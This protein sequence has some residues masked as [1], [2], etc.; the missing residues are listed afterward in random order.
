MKKEISWTKKVFALILSGVLLLSSIPVALATDNSTKD[1]PAD[2][3]GSAAT[4]DEALSS[5]GYPKIA[6]PTNS[7]YLFYQDGDVVYIGKDDNSSKKMVTVSV[8]ADDLD[9]GIAVEMAESIQSMQFKQFTANYSDSGDTVLKS[10]ELIDNNAVVYK[11]DKGVFLF[12]VDLRTIPVDD[13]LLGFSIV[14]KDNDNELHE[15]YKTGVYCATLPNVSGIKYDGKDESEME[16][17]NTSIEIEATVTESP[18]F[19]YVTIDGDTASLNGSG[20]YVMTVSEARTAEIRV[21]NKFGTY[22]SAETASIKS[23]TSAPFVEYCNFV[24]ENGSEFTGWSN[25]KLTL[26]VNVQDTE[27]GAD[28]SSIKLSDGTL[29]IKTESEGNSASAYFEISEKADFTIEFA[30]KVGN[31]DSYDVPAENVNIDKEAPKASDF[32]LTFSDAQNA[33]DKFLNFLTFGAYSNKDVKITIDVNDNDLSEIASVKLYNGETE[34]EKNGDAF[35]LTAPEND[36]E[37]VEY[38]LFVEATDKAGNSS[39]KIRFNQSKDIKTKLSD[40]EAVRD[41]S[42]NLY[43][44]V[45]SKVVPSLDETYADK[46]VNRDFAHIT[47]NDGKY[48]V[49]GNGTISVKLTEAN[50]GIKEIK[51]TLDGG[52]VPVSLSASQEGK[53]TEQIASVSVNN[54]SEGEHTVKF[55]ATANSGMQETYEV[56]VISVKK[57]PQLNGALKFSNQDESGKQSWVNTDV[58]ITFALKDSPVDV[59]SVKYYKYADKTNTTDVEKTTDG[60]KFTVGE[61]ATYTVVA[62]DVLGNVSEFKTS[63]AVLIDKSNPEVVNEKFDYTPAWINKSVKIKFNVKDNPAVCSGVSKVTV[64]GEEIAFTGGKCEFEATEYGSHSV[65]V[66]DAAGNFS[67]TYTVGPVNIDLIA[68]EVKSVTFSAAN[69]VNEYGIYA[70]EDLTMSVVFVDP[71]NG[72]GVCS[73]INMAEIR[74][75]K[76]GAALSPDSSTLY[77]NEFTINYTL[78]KE[79]TEIRN[80]YY[81]VTDNAGNEAEFKLVNNSTVVNVDESAALYEVVATLA[82]P[83]ISDIKESFTKKYTNENDG[84]TYYSGS[85]KFTSSIKDELAGIDSYSTYFVKKDAV[86]KDADGNITSVDGTPLTDEKEVSKDS[87]KTSIDK[88]EIETPSVD[89]LESG[90]YTAVIYAK[91]LSGNGVY[92]SFDVIVD[93]TAPQITGYSIETSGDTHSNYGVYSDSDINV[94]VSFADDVYSTGIKSVKFYNGNTELG[95]EKVTVSGNKATITLSACAQYLLSAKVIDNFDHDTGVIAINS[96][97]G[98]KLNDVTFVPDDKNFEIVVNNDNKKLEYSDPAYSFSPYEYTEQNGETT[99]RVLKASDNGTIT[100]SVQNTLSG[101]MDI[102]TKMYRVDGSN[103]IDVTDSIT[104][105]ESNNA[106]D[107]DKYDK[108][109]KK[110]VTID[111]RQI[112]QSGEYEFVITATDFCGLKNELKDTFYLDMTNPEY[113]SMNIHRAEPSVADQVLKVLSFGVFSNNDMEV[114]VVLNDNGPTAGLTNSCISLMSNSGLSVTEKADSLRVVSGDTLSGKIYEITYVLHKTDNNYI[115]LTKS[116]YKDLKFWCKDRFD[117]S[118]YDSAF[119]PKFGV[120]SNGFNINLGSADIVTSAYAPKISNVKLTGDNRYT[121]GDGDGDGNVWFS[122]NP[123]FEFDANDEV[124]RLHSFSVTLNDPPVSDLCVCNGSLNNYN[125]TTFNDNNADDNNAD[126]DL[127][128]IHVVLNTASDA[129]SQYVKEGRNEIKYNVTSNNGISSSNNGISSEDKT[130][131]FYRDTEIPVIQSITFANKIDP[132]MVGYGNNGVKYNKN[133]GYFFQDATTVTVTATDL[134]NVQGSGVRS[135]YLYTKSVSDSEPQLLKQVDNPTLIDAANNVYQ[136]EFDIRADFKG[137]IYAFAVDNVMNNINAVRANGHGFV[138]GIEDASIKVYTPDSVIAETQAQFESNGNA[139]VNISRVTSTSSKDRTGRDLYSGPVEVSLEAYSKFAGIK[140]IQCIVTAAHYN[141]GEA[142]VDTTAQV[143]LSGNISDGWTA[144]DID[145]NLVTRATKKITVNNNSNDIK[146]EL[147]ITDRCGY[148]TKTEDTFSIDTVKPTIKVE[149][150]PQRGNTEI[151]DGDY[152]KTDR[153]ATITVYE[154]N[155]D[156]DSFEYPVHDPH[157]GKPV[158]AAVENWSRGYALNENEPDQTVHVCTLTFNTDGDYEFELTSTDLAGNKS[159][160]YKTDHVFTIDKTLPKISITFDVNNPRP[161]Y[162][163]TRTATIRIEEHNFHTPYVDIKQTAFGA[164]NSTPATPPSVSAWSTSGDVSTAT[165]TFADDG[166][167]SFTVDFKDKALNEAVQQREGDFYVDKKIDKIEI[168]NVKD[169][170]AYDGTIAP[171]IH[172]FD[173]NFDTATYL[174][175]RIDFGKAAETVDDLTVSEGA[176]NGFSKIV[177]YADFERITKNDGI[178]DLSADITDLAGNKDHKEVVFSVNRFGSTFMI[179]DETTKQ[180]VED[181]FYTNNAPDIV[182]TEINVNEVSDPDIQVNCDDASQTLKKDTDYTITASGGQN[183]WYAYD[184]KIFKQNFVN[185]G[186]YTVTVSS[187]D[188]FDNVVSNKTAYKSET[189]NRTCPVKFVVDKTA[190]IVTISG[191]DSNEYYK[192]AEK[193]VIVSCED[194]NITGENLTVELD[195]ERFVSYDKDET[196]GNIEL[197]LSLQADGNNNERDFKVTVTD[198]AGNK[199]ED[200]EVTGFI[201]GASW[202]ARLFRYNLP[203]VIIVGA[204]V[205]GGIAFGVVMAVRKNNKKKAE[206]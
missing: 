54:L 124:S 73:N 131:V 132:S 65:I 206:S 148:T 190:P 19:D 155:F 178:Y 4:E 63:S 41:L 109:V 157:G 33:G 22:T 11:N 15:I 74:E 30:D 47:E 135:I 50:T 51:A 175:K 136:A 16:W 193:E 67:K 187:K 32:T 28:A 168:V 3:I 90:E 133:Y 110:T 195:G 145:Q 98:V 77:G 10:V 75:S 166:K 40:G 104:A 56:S 7:S 142:P 80:Y 160:T 165:I 127:S 125:F 37:A 89:Q 140:T 12:R 114:T 176:G 60:Y 180:L 120:T 167:Y 202:L 96:G 91:N 154:R 6:P 134:I 143:D 163:V 105:S 177:T 186:N 198:K 24:D 117:N 27:S 188:H 95:D 162:N 153:V 130:V 122:N 38:D 46:G 52:S 97:V 191:I 26:K 87:K 42:E 174:L 147:I 1:E 53:V 181:K 151:S 5:N 79:N 197:K 49:S 55:Y 82:T 123:T 144:V 45:L 84:K 158:F 78:K 179:S 70:K 182:V 121:D 36:G 129:L 93:N 81:Y 170:T 192:E 159:D 172:Y 48:Y 76:D 72:S 108:Y 149:F 101:I 199:N 8:N 62:T 103:R 59:A 61:Y 88:V 71:L 13:Q 18:V 189:E 194:A 43:E 29:P 171:E 57:G 201:L 173:Q 99:I 85:G 156:P 83:D 141:S 138:P 23:D 64:D 185:E 205:L 115:A 14:Y 86:H 9:P 20:E 107:K 31:S 94:T 34:I 164:D 118:Q 116:S 111:A 25:D 58:D 139:G 68:P 92:N 112:K 203:L 39:G 196:S 21:Y 2:E 44:V 102:E 152:Y 17:V 184:Y 126:T 183:Q 204:L 106:S 150:N 66:Y 200:G 100:A 137:Q 146:I 35:I 169:L 69:K 161:Y 113:E 128:G 119:A